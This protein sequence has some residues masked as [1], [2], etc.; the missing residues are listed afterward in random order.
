M[1]QTPNRKALQSNTLSAWKRLALLV[2]QPDHRHACARPITAPCG[3]SFDDWGTLR[4]QK[5][6]LVLLET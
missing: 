5:M 6:L 1:R 4:Y 3:S 2:P